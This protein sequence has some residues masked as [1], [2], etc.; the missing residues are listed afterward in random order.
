VHCTAEAEARQSSRWFPRGDPRVL[1]L[2]FD[3]GQ[4]EQLPGPKLAREKLA[5]AL[6]DDGVPVVLF[7]SRLHPK[8]RLETLIGSAAQLRDEGVACRFIVAGTGDADYEQA[9]RR[10]VA[11]RNLAGQFEFVGFVSGREKLSLFEA[12][13]LFVLPTH[14]ENWGFV[15]VEALACGVPVVTTRGVDI[16]SELESSGGAVIID[17]EPA[18]LA[19]TIRGLLEDRD[20]RREMGSRGRAWVLESLHPD[21]VISGYVDLYDSIADGH[22]RTPGESPSYL[23]DGT[24]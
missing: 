6:P 7:L 2:V 13:D 3:I 18:P 10:L 14:Q 23:P 15:L 22:G 24:P 4:F 16:W 20:R 12:S 1:P 11:D 9:L 5:S 8:K 19:A 21:R 17:A